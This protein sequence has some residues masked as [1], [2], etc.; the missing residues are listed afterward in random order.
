MLEEGDQVLVWTATDVDDVLVGLETLIGAHVPQETVVFLDQRQHFLACGRGD[1]A[2]DMAA[3]TVADQAART[4]QIS[5]EIGMGIEEDGLDARA[6]GIPVFV[7]GEFHAVEGISAHGPV[8]AGRR[9]KDADFDW[10][11]HVNSKRKKPTT[12][13]PAIGALWGNV[14]R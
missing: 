11:Q 9:I 14:A 7:E 6:A 13:V 2:D 1:R 5:C 3:A 10:V 8:R 4:F 12:R